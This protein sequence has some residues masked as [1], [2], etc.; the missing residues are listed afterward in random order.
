MV[1][2]LD[3]VV[4]STIALEGDGSATEYAGGYSDYL[5][6]R[7]PRLV[8]A[9]PTPR[10]EPKPAPPARAPDS[11]KP[12]KLTGRQ[13]RTLDELP[14]KIDALHAEI[15]ALSEA[16][17]DPDLYRRDAP[18]FS[19]KT[20]RLAAAQAELDAAEHTWLELEMLREALA[21]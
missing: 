19:V 10:A 12:R 4:T 2:F 1:D 20:A 16:L 17:A 3:R 9:A 15:A 11:R 18:S 14:T 5:L 6:Q 21:G 13:Q 8:V 7:G